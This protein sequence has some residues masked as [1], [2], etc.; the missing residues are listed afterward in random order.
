MIETMLS[1]PQ[2]GAIG[3]HFSQVSIIQEAQKQGKNALVMEDD[4]V[5]CSDLHERLAI[6]EGFLEGREWDVFWLG[7]TF[8]VNYKGEG[9]F[10]HGSGGSK[11]RPDCSSHL[12]RDAETTDNPRIMRTYGAF[13]TFAYIVNVKS[14]D[15]IL[16]LFNRHLHSSIGIDWLFIKLQPQLKCFAFVPGCVKQFDGQSDIGIGVTKFSGFGQLNGTVDN[17][18]YWFADRMEQFDPL[19]FNW[20]ECKV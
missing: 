20:Y 4:L 2:K 16:A 11:M 18:R 9:A 1:R 8:H 17:S 5:F 12:G 10:W 3:C 7:G 15:K 13:S 14:I 19:T 6:I